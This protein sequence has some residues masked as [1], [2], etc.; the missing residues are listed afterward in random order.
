MPPALEDVD[1]ANRLLNAVVGHGLLAF[2]MGTGV[3]LEFDD[4]AYH[5]LTIEGS[6]RFVR[7]DGSERH[8]EPI[9]LD[10]AEQLIQLLNAPVT[11]AAVDPYGTLTVT[12]GDADLVVPNDEMYEAW[13]IRSDQGLLVVS[14]PGGDLAIWKPE[15]DGP[16]RR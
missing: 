5:E 8:G 7:A 14:M 13:Q 3:R 15:S 2:R 11:A 10:V 4:D 6:L 1:L 16:D 9:S 12:F